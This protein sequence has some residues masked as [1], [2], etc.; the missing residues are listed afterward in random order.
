MLFRKE[1]KVFIIATALSYFGPDRHACLRPF[2]EE[3]PDANT[4]QHCE[5][6][7]DTTSHELIL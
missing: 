7:A 5:H 3:H 4:T 1:L 2:T 6:I